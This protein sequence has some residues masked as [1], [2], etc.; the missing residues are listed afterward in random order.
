MQQK[1][2][3]KPSH[4]NFFGSLAK[5]LEELQL[6]MAFGSELSRAAFSF[7]A[8]SFSLAGIHLEEIFGVRLQ[9][10]QMDA[11]ILRLGLVIVRVRGFRGLAQTAGARS[12]MDDAAT[13]SVRSPSDDRP[14][15]A[16]TL[17]SWAVS[18]FDCLRLGRVFWRRR[19]GSS[20]G[21]C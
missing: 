21:R 4:V 8:G 10:L 3:I 16:G 15:R 1:I 11:M 12:I 7:S 13:T 14:G 19:G 5:P 18:D 20:Q 17:D 6:L 2:T 9:V